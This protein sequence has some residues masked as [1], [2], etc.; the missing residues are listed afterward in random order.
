MRDLHTRAV[1]YLALAVAMSGTA[2]AATGGGFIL[3]RNNTAGTTTKLASTDV[4]LELVAPAGTAPL[5][6]NRTVRVANLNADLIDGYSSDQLQRRIAGTCPDGQAMRGANAQ[7][8][9]LCTLLAPPPASGPIQTRDKQWSISDLQVFQE[10]GGEDWDGRARITN[11]ASTTRSSCFTVTLFR[12]GVVIALLDGCA[13]DVAPG[14][15]Y[16]VD[17]FTTDN[18][19]PGAFTSTFQ[20]D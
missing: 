1:A 12:D 11:E 10:E 3:G 14:N 9:P 4:P 8:T 7:G 16:S 6:V 15:T 5:Q 17:L 19:S 18:Y 20:A 2:M 13:I